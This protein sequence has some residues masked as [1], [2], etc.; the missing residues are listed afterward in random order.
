MTKRAD[1]WMPL[2]IGDY[3]RD[4]MRLTRD[5]H[6]GYLLLLMECWNSG[7][8]LPNDP[9]QL[10]A[11]AKASPGEWKRLSPVLL[12]Y[13]KVRGE[14]LYHS[15]VFK[16]RAKA[17]KLLETKRENGRKGGRPRKLTETDE[18]PTGSANH[19]LDRNLDHNLDETPARVMVK[20]DSSEIDLPP[21][22]EGSR[23]SQ[24]SSRAEVIPLAGRGAA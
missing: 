3:M 17:Q 19:N 12:P 22:Q 23:D 15:R 11:I 7:G 16:E 18:K 8:R 10:A 9:A 4:T 6:G 2:Y 14:W 5:Q 1:A 24:V 21:S 13:F 20:V